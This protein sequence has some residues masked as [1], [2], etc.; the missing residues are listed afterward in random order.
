M[1]NK[2]EG[3]EVHALVVAELPRRHVAVV[4]CSSSS[5]AGARGGSKV[6]APLP[7]DKGRVAGGR[8]AHREGE[9]KAAAA[10]GPTLM[11]LRTCSGGMS[12]FC[13]SE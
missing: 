5:S 4:L 3:A 13:A 12:S 11:I 1:R 6:S 2:L 7:M 10:G 8:R 9:P